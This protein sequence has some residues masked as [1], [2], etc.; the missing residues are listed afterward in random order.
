MIAKNYIVCVYVWVC[1]DSIGRM[2]VPELV[3][4]EDKEAIS[5]GETDTAWIDLYF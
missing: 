3:L 2:L 5:E 1:I 4:I